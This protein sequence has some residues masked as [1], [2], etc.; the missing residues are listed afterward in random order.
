MKKME[1]LELEAYRSEMSDDM[2]H[3]FEKY[4]K[5]FNWDIPE[6]DQTTSDPLILKAMHDALDEIT[7][8]GNNS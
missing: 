2:R 4:R 7:L 6:L 3:L 5:I 1:Q 8:D